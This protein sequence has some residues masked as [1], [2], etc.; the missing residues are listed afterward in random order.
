VADAS[1]TGSS[2]S[3]EIRIFCLNTSSVEGELLPKV[4]GQG[5]LLEDFTYLATVMVQSMGS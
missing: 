2:R 1:F 4:W 5:N 3:H